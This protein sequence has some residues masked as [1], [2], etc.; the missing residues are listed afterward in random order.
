VQHIAAR[1][2]SDPALMNPSPYLI[3]RAAEVRSGPAAACT[4]IGDQTTDVQAARVIGAA[5]IGYAN[6]PGKAADLTD[7]GADAIVVRISEL[8][9][10][11]RAG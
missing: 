8:T 1:D 4:L 9:E 11:V 6:K 7:A 10:A 2:P 3:H 5:S